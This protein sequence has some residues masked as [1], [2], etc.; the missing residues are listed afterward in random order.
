MN[1]LCASGRAQGN[2]HA[3]SWWLWSWIQIFREKNWQPN[4]RI[5]FVYL[6]QPGP[7]WPFELCVLLCGAAVLR[8]CMS[9]AAI[10]PYATHMMVATERSHLKLMS[11]QVG[12]FT[13][14]S[15]PVAASLRTNVE[16]P[17]PSRFTA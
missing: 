15:F 8:W 7:A 17:P 5:Y 2:R 3:R 9:A 4:R 10:R 14:T 12:Q 11:T 6:C 1:R 16:D 13:T